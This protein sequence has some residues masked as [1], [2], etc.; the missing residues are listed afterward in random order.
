MRD[1]AII[2]EEIVVW[3]REFDLAQ[4]ECRRQCPPVQPLDHSRPVPVLSNAC[5]EATRKRFE[6]DKRVEELFREYRDA[7]Q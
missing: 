3:V 5:I 7:R 4:E 6:L 1:K 2:W